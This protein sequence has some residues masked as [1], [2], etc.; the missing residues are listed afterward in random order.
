MDKRLTIDRIEEGFAIVECDGQTFELPMQALPKDCQEGDLLTI[1]CEKVDQS[2]INQAKDR[3]KRLQE[4]DP[5][6]DVIE[7]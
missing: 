5:G 7:L 6:D 2:R 4:R 1:V 3:L